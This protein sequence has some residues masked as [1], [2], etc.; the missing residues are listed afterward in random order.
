MVDRVALT[1]ADKAAAG[2][3]GA[4]D[5]FKSLKTFQALIRVSIY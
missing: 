5:P 4:V 3:S 1:A 2:G